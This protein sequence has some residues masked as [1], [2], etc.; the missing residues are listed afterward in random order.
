M[1][2]YVFSS[3]EYTPPYVCNFN[4]A[5]L[6]FWSRYSW[7][8]KKNIALVPNTNTPVSIFNVNDAPGGACPNNRA[9]YVDNIT[10]TFFT[11]D[12]YTTLFTA[13]EKVQPCQ[14]YH[15]K[16]VIADVEMVLIAVYSS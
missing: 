5:L 8:C 9:Y 11:H 14:T 6:Y 13:I 4:Y 3:E 16:L 7:R 1:L 15:L 2:R 12:G 10:N